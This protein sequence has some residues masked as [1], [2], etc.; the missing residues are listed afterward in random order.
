[1]ENLSDIMLNPSALELLQP[2][3]WVLRKFSPGAGRDFVVGDIHGEFGLLEDLLAFQDFKPEAD[4]LFCL[5][6][7]VD[8]GPF[9]ALAVKFL[10]QLWFFSLRGNH[11]QMLLDAP[12]A[13]VSTIYASNYDLT[14]NGAQWWLDLSDDDRWEAL[15]AYGNLPF[16]MELP[17]RSGLKV[18]L[19]HGEVTL[20][21]SWQAFV[22]AVSRRDWD[23]MHS[24]LWGRNRV[25]MGA[26]SPVPGIDWV[27]SGHTIVKE[28]SQLGNVLFIDTGGCL[29]REG[30][31]CLPLVAL[32]PVLKELVA[33]QAQPPVAPG[34]R[35]S[36]GA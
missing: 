6:D 32:E 29:H 21:Q 20:N 22:A 33:P 19:V 31:G 16:L 3:A 4:R 7:L 25:K 35:T 12:P 27:I 26:K 30:Q 8:R 18:G 1:M 24:A 28:P 23:A 9:S 34:N 15:E 13:G 36:R 5:G 2:P 14:R 17:T 10:A 11:E